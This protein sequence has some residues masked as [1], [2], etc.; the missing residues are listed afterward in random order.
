MSI[1]T[2]IVCDGCGKSVSCGFGRDRKHA[3]AVR[4]ELARGG[5]SISGAPDGDLCGACRPARRKTRAGATKSEVVNSA[6]GGR[7]G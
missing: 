2:Q 4:T 6:E 7:R 5:W 3:H 1:A